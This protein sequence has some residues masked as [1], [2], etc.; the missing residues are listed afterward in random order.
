MLGSSFVKCCK[1]KT[2]TSISLRQSHYCLLES[3][4]RVV[5]LGKTGAGKSSLTDSSAKSGTTECQAENKCVNGRR[6]MWIDTPG[7]F[8]TDRAQEEMKPEILRCI[9]ECA[10][11]PHVF[12]ILLKVEKFTKHE[13]E[14]IDEIQKYF[15]EEALKFAI[16]V[17]SHGDQLPEEMKIEEFVEQCE[18]LRDLVKK[19]GGRC[20]VVD[21][22]Y[23]KTKEQDEYR[24]NQFQVEELLKT[25][26]KLIEENK[27]GCFTT[28]R[29]QII[30]MAKTEVLAKH[31]FK[32]AGVTTGALLGAFIGGAMKLMRQGT[33]TAALVAGVAIG[34]A[35][36]VL[37][38]VAA[39]SGATAEEPTSPGDAVEK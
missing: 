23:W 10:P 7:F 2:L 17:F 30:Y 35:A 31:M 16:V 1:I 6:I 39:T 26:D 38:G 32:F 18:S 29:I 37:A 3:T 34:T 20:H 33:P 21:N 13:Q 14:V 36:G 12:L 25:I 22:K 9:I 11:G 19:C 27:G 5:V 15:S 28:E 24:A 4:K 8:D